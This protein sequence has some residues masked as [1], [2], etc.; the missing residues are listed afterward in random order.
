MGSQESNLQPIPT[1]LLAQQS[2]I[3]SCAEDV[4][5]S[6]RFIRLP[7]TS[8]HFSCAPESRAADLA[9]LSVPGMLPAQM[10]PTCEIGWR[11]PWGT[12]ELLVVLQT[13]TGDVAKRQGAL[14]HLADERHEG[15]AMRKTLS[16]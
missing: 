3:R 12:Q 9:E 13:D 1:L 8:A 5:L 2:K 15:F 7:E 10:L 16:H 4:L 14:A 11:G 6:L